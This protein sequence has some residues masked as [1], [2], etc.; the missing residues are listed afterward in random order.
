M[1]KYSYQAL[2]DHLG[3]EMCSAMRWVS[4]L[5]TAYMWLCGLLAP[6]AEYAYVGP[7]KF[8]KL[9]QR[10]IFSLG[11]FTG[12]YG[13]FRMGQSFKTSKEKIFT[14]HAA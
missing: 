4:Y 7:W 1:K 6:I 13:L 2:L 10:M 11:M 8:Y 5:F 14:V 9:W 3:A 12:G